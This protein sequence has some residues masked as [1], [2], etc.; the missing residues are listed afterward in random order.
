MKCQDL[1]SVMMV[2]CF[3]SVSTLFK[4]YRDDERVIIEGCVQ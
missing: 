2:W 1:F 3:T 4:S